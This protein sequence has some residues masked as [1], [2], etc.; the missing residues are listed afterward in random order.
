[1][2]HRDSS[3]KH[4]ADPPRKALAD[5]LASH[6]R[7][8]ATQ[9]LWPGTIP[10]LN[11]IVTALETDKSLNVVVFESAVEGFFLTHYDFLAK[12]EDSTSLPPDPRDCSNYLTCWCASVVRPS[13]L[14][15]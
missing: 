2:E 1:M 5:V 3:G 12:L 6:L 8:P 15:R 11:E 14:S 4:E 13:Y 7:S 9:Y 10:Q